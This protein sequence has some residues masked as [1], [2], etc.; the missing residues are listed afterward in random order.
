MLHNTNTLPNVKK[1]LWYFMYI[2]E[3]Y[4]KLK[5]RS[6]CKYEVQ[7]LKLIFNYKV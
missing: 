2:I 3:F 6:I 1:E 5:N 4:S 7:Q